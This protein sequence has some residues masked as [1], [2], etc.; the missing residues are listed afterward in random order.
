MNLFVISK[1]DV[2]DQEKWR[3]L[4]IGKRV[5]KINFSCCKTVSF[6]QIRITIRTSIEQLDE[7]SQGLA[8]ALRIARQTAGLAFIFCSLY[9]L[10]LIIRKLEKKSFHVTK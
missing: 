10:F 2:A 1:S 5:F 7:T 6:S 4:R 3:D 9:L 8:L